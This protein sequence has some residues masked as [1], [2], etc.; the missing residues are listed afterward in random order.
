PTAAAPSSGGSVVIVARAGSLLADPSLLTGL[1]AQG[2][3]A[4]HARSLGERVA[5]AVVF[6]AGDSV[7]AAVE[8]L[9]SRPP[10][11]VPVLIVLERVDAAAMRRL[12]EAGAAD[13]I[14]E[15]VAPDTLAKKL[16]RL[17]RRR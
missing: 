7:D 8:V 15:P 14:A 4:A 16:K 17:L 6:D 11:A 9:G 5:D 12:I 13:V 1:A 2:M 3:T 10:G